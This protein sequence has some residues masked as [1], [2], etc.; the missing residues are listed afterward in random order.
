MITVRNTDTVCLSRA[1][2]TAHANLGKEKWTETQLKDGF[3]KS[4][5]LQGT[6]AKKLH[7]DA[8]VPI[9]DYGNTL[10][11]VNTFAEHL[12]VQIN[13]VDANYFNEII[14]TANPGADKNIYLYKNKNHYDVITSMPAFLSKNIIV[15]RVKK[16][17]RVATNTS[18]QTSVCRVLNLKN[19]RVT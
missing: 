11:D 1:I 19:I 5:A 2:V 16:D 17:I 13:I 7:E 12:G 14:H 3:N 10:E 8:S 18:V 6:E 4:R 15:I 9:T